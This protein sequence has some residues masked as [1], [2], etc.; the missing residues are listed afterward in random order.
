MTQ[1]IKEGKLFFM[2]RLAHEIN[3]RGDTSHPIPS[4]LRDLSLYKSIRF[5][6]L[7]SINNQNKQFKAMSILWREFFKSRGIRGRCG[8]IHTTFLFLL[9]FVMG[10]T[11]RSL[12][13][14]INEENVA[15]NF[16]LL[17]IGSPCI[18]GTGRVIRFQLSTTVDGASEQTNSYFTVDFGDGTPIVRYDVNSTVN[19]DPSGGKTFLYSYGDSFTGNHTYKT[20][21]KCF[22][23]VVTQWFDDVGNGYK[24]TKTKIV[25]WDTDDK[26]PDGLVIGDQEGDA[27]KVVNDAV[28]GAPV[29]NLCASTTGY[30]LTSN[31]FKD[32]SDWNCNLKDDFSEYELGDDGKYPLNN[33]RRLVIWSYGIKDDS[34]LDYLDGVVVYDASGPHT[35]TSTE[36]VEP[37]IEYPDAGNNIEVTP[38]KLPGVQ[39]IDIPSTTNKDVGKVF[40]ITLNDENACGL[41]TSPAIAYIKIVG[42][43]NPEVEDKKICMPESKSV[44]VTFTDDS[45]LTPTDIVWT[46]TKPDGSAE[47]AVSIA[48]GQ[49]T[50]TITIDLSKVDLSTTGKI[51]FK[52]NVRVVAGGDVC[53]GT[54][55][56]TI[57]ILKQPDPDFNLGGT[58]TTVTKKVCQSGT[59]QLSYDKTK[60]L[61]VGENFTL[62][63]DW[64]D[65]VS[66][67]IY[68]GTGGAGTITFNHTYANTTDAVQT[69]NAT[70]TVSNGTC[71]K[72]SDPH[73]V[74]VYPKPTISGAAGP[75]CAKPSITERY[76]CSADY[77]DLT[78]R[79]DVTLPDG[80]PHLGEGLKRTLD[81][82]F[83]QNG[84]YKLKV[85]ISDGG[86]SQE[87]DEYDVVVDKLEV[88]KSSFTKDKVCADKGTKEAT[89]ELDLSKPTK[90]R[91]GTT[92]TVDWGSGGTAEVY[93]VDAP[94]N[95]RIKYGASVPD[96][97]ITKTYTYTGDG[98][99]VDER[100]VTVTFSNSTGSCSS[101]IPLKAK[102][103]PPVDAGFNLPLS[104][105][106]DEEVTFDNTSKGVNLSYEW[107]VKKG[108]A[109]IGTADNTVKDLVHTFATS[110]DYLVGLEVTS[111]DGCPGETVPFK[112]YEVV[113]ITPGFRFVKNSGYHIIPKTQKRVDDIEVQ[114]TNTLNFKPGT[115]YKFDFG[116]TKGIVALHN[117]DFDPVTHIYTDVDYTGLTTNKFIYPVELTESRLGCVYSTTRNISIYSVGA[118]FIVTPVDAC[119]GDYQLQD[120]SDISDDFKDPG[121]P[122]EHLFVVR[123]WSVSTDGGL[124]YTSKGTGELF[125]LNY[126]NNSGTD[127]T[128]Y[129]KLDLIV[130]IDGT[131][132][133]G[134]DL[135]KTFTAIQHF[136]VP[137]A[138]QVS[139][140]GTDHKVC[141]GN[142]L[143][144]RPYNVSS[145]DAPDS[146]VDWTVS[147]SAYSVDLKSLVKRKSI[148][149]LNADYHVFVFNSEPVAG[150]VYT[151]NFTVS[152]NI[153]NHHSTSGCTAVKTYNIEV[154]D[155]SIVDETIYSCIGKS[156]TFTPT[157]GGGGDPVTRS[158]KWEVTTGSS[159]DLNVDASIT[160][161]T[162]DV[163]YDNFVFVPSV[164][165]NYVIKYTATDAGGCEKSHNFAL[166]VS[167]QPDP[168]TSAIQLGSNNLV[169]VT[170]E[171]HYRVCG[172]GVTLDGLHKGTVPT[173]DMQGE[174]TFLNKPSGAGDPTITTF[175]GLN[176]SKV[177]VTNLVAGEYDF[178]YTLRNH[179]SGVDASSLACV[180]SRI[181]KVN[182]YD[183]IS[184]TDA[185]LIH[186]VK[187]DHAL[188]SGVALSPEINVTGG[189]GTYNFAW[190]LV[191]STAGP[192]VWNSTDQNP[193][194]S[195][196]DVDT[197]TFTVTVTDQEDGVCVATKDITMSVLENVSAEAVAPDASTA[198]GSSVQPNTGHSPSTPIYI[199][200]GKKIVLNGSN[201]YPLGTQPD[202]SA[203]DNIT[204][205]WSVTNKDGVVKT[206]VFNWRKTDGS[207]SNNFAQEV[208]VEADAYGEYTFVYTI[209]NTSDPSVPIESRVEV[210]VTFVRPI[211]VTIGGPLTICPVGTEDVGGGVT[212]KYG[213]DG[214]SSSYVYT[215]TKDGDPSGDYSG[216]LIED[217]DP[218]AGVIGITTPKI[219]FDAENATAGI[220]NV[221]LTVKDPFNGLSSHS[222]VR[223]VTVTPALDPQ[224]A[225]TSFVPTS[226]GVAGTVQKANIFDVSSP[227]YYIVGRELTLEGTDGGIALTGSVS[228]RWEK[229][230]GASW[231]LITNNS[232][233]N[234]VSTGE[235][236]T[237]PK[238]PYGLMTIR[239]NLGNGICYNDM[240]MR[241]HFI[242]PIQI[243]SIDPKYFCH[244]AANYSLLNK[245]KVSGGSAEGVSYQWNVSDGAKDVTLLTLSNSTALSPEIL[246][247]TMAVGDYTFTLLVTD[248]H[249]NIQSKSM[250]FEVHIL[251]NPVADVAFPG[252]T[253]GTKNVIL[254]GSAYKVI[255]SDASIDLT[256]LNT[257]T[258]GKDP[259]ANPDLKGEWVMLAGPDADTGDSWYSNSKV[260]TYTPKTAGVYSFQWSLTNITPTGVEMCESSKLVEVEFL[261]GLS[262]TPQGEQ[263]LC[264]NGG[265]SIDLKDL[266]LPT[267][268]SGSYTNYR[269]TAEKRDLDDDAGSK[270]NATPSIIDSNSPDAVLPLTQEGIYYISLEVDDAK[271]VG[272]VTATQRMVI[273]PTEDANAG[274]DQ[275]T[276][277]ESVD[278][279]A[280]A[281][282]PIDGLTREGTWT[283]SPASTKVMFMPTSVGYTDGTHDPKAKFVSILGTR[284]RFTLTW[285][286]NSEKGESCPISDQM[287]VDFVPPITIGQFFD[288]R[289]SDAIV[290][291]GED[292]F[293]HPV[294]AGGSEDKAGG[295]IDNYT[296]SW[297]TTGSYDITSFLRDPATF[298]ASDP[299][300]DVAV[301]NKRNLILKTA[302][303]HPGDYTLTLEVSDPV[304]GYC[305][306]TRE[307]DIKI[308][309]T[310]VAEA[311]VKT[312]VSFE[313]VKDQ[314]R[315]RYYTCRKTVELLGSNVGMT[316]DEHGV[317]VAGTAVGHVG[318]KGEW[319]KVGGPGVITFAKADG[320]EGHEDPNAQ[321]IFS[322]AGEYTIQW[323]VYNETKGLCESTKVIVVDVKEPITVTFKD[324]PIYVC[325]DDAAFDITP[326]FSGGSGSGYT[327]FVWTIATVVD[328]AAT[329]GTYH[330]D[331]TGKS[332]GVYTLGVTANDKEG[333]VCQG[334]GDVDV[335]IVKKPTPNIKKGVVEFCGTS[336]SLSADALMKET[337][338]DKEQGRWR[339]KPD[340]TSDGTVTF[341]PASSNNTDFIVSNKGH[342]IFEWVVDHIYK[343]VA[344]VEVH[345]C[346][347]VDEIEI[348]VRITP[349]VTIEAP[350]H[351]EC[352]KDIDPILNI[353]GDY[354]SVFWELVSGPKITSTA[355]FSDNTV[356][357]PTVTVNDYGKY[358]FRATVSNGACSDQV[359]EMEYTFASQPVAGFDIT[360]DLEGC[361]PLSVTVNNSTTGDAL[362]DYAYQ[363]K[364][365]DP[366]DPTDAT[367]L[368][369]DKD[370]GSA[371]TIRNMSN[372]VKD[373]NIVLTV[374]NGFCSSTAGPKPV[375]VHPMP[376]VDFN[377]TSDSGCSPVVAEMENKTLFA[378][379]YE[380]D[381]DEDGTW[382]DTS[383]NPTHT[384][385]NSDFTKFNFKIKLRATKTTNDAFGTP[386][387]CP[388]TMEKIISVSPKP[389]FKLESDAAASGVCSPEEV[390]FT[391]TVGAIDYVWNYGDGS[392][393]TTTHYVAMQDHEFTYPASSDPVTDPFVTYKV[394]VDATFP[395]GCPS[396]GEVDVKVYPEMISNF[397]PSKTEV[398]SGEE[399]TFT[400]NAAPGAKKYIW[401]FNGDIVEQT[402]FEPTIDHTFNI[403]GY[404]MIPMNVSLT[405]ENDLCTETSSQVIMVKPKAKAD[406]DFLAGKDSFCSGE[407]V[408]FVN[409]SV[410]GKTFTWDYGEGTPDDKGYY[411]YTNTG[412]T[413]ITKTVTLIADNGFCPHDTSRVITI[414]HEVKPKWS[415][416]VKKG[417]TPLT[418]E[419]TNETVGGA[420]ATIS[421]GDGTPDEVVT[422]RGTVTHVFTNDKE[423]EALYNVSMT[424]AANAAGDCRKTLRDVIRVSP[425]IH[426]DF[427]FV[428]DGTTFCSGDMVMF[429]N[430]TIGV[431]DFDWDYGDGSTGKEAYHQYSN[432]T[433]TDVPRK[434]KLQV[435][436]YFGCT[437]E[438][439]KEITVM[440]EAQPRMDVVV[441]GEC[442]PVTVTV[443]NNTTGASLMTLDWG[444]GTTPVDVSTMAVG[445]TKTYEYNNDDVYIKT[446]DI[447]LSAAPAA[448]GSCLKTVSHRVTVKPEV[449]ASFE[450][451]KGGCSPL[452]ASVTNNSTG[453]IRYN[454]DFGVDSDPK[455]K[456]FM[457]A[458]KYIYRNTTL[459][460]QKY[461]VQLIAISSFGCRDTVNSIPI[462]IKPEPSVSFSLN[463]DIREGCAPLKSHFVV[464]SK[465]ANKH[466]WEI[467]KG[468]T[469]VKNIVNDEFGLYEEEFDHVY[470]NTDVF[471]RDFTLRLTGEN[472]FG[473]KVVQTTEMNIK[474]EVVSDFD[475]SIGEVCSPVTVVFSAASKSTG[476]SY[477][478]WDFGNDSTSVIPNPMQVF[479]NDTDKPKEF[480]VKL[481]TSSGECYG[482]SSK[483]LTIQ[484]HMEANFDLDKINGCSPVEVNIKN[485]SIRC[486][487]YIWSFDGGATAENI[488]DKI[489]SRTF[490][491]SRTSSSKFPD[492]RS[493]S[494]NATN[495]Y[496]RST[497]TK[498][499]KIFAPAKAGFELSGD[500]HCSPAKV[501]FI[502][503]SDHSYDVA[504]DFDDGSI[505]NLPNPEHLFLNESSTE[506]V[507]HIKQTVTTRDK[508]SAE[509]IKTY[510]MHPTPKVDFSI[511]PIFMIWPEATVSVENL[512][513][514][515]PWRFNWSFGEYEGVAV[516]DV[517][518]DPYTYGRVGS[519]DVKLEVIGE[520]CT[521][522]HKETVTIRPGVPVASFTPS[523]TE[524]CGPLKVKFT[525]TSKNGA[526]YYWD[527]GDGSH[528]TQ[529]NPEHTFHEENFYNV[530]LT[531]RNE[532][533]TKSEAEKTIH[534]FPVPVAFFTVQ[535]T[536]VEIPGQKAIFSN[537]SVNNFENYWEFGDGTTTTEVDP[538]HEY[539]VQG[540][541]DVKLRVVSEDGCQHTFTREA[542]VTAVSNGRVKVPNAFVPSTNGPT[543]GRYDK[544]DTYNRFFYSIVPEGEAKVSKYD[545]KIVNRWGNLVFHTSD[546]NI[547]WDGY[548]NGKLAPMDVYI[549]QIEVSFDDG[550]TIIQSGDVTLIR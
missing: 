474:P 279:N 353:E 498:P 416:N 118:D 327:D 224:V 345:R 342:Y 243:E 222:K 424:V 116:G 422:A 178:T 517:N 355:N 519:F 223:K 68:N 79:W 122:G 53:D 135:S 443:T 211:R 142:N 191:G 281:V 263:A 361:S 290:C 308:K 516:H 158:H 417:C 22:Y 31:P 88:S 277:G 536:R 8:F 546:I 95:L 481:V 525:N 83:D 165:G 543:D 365:V 228:G 409:K 291:A 529:E 130:T 457:P 275:Q 110:G 93:E 500:G 226:F 236:S 318:I 446:F 86:C 425:L 258:S 538:E 476:A 182:V 444:D 265:A 368:S 260:E 5:R 302:K 414:I 199:V 491:Y 524:G 292:I 48:S 4:E 24:V 450:L 218:V 159:S 43:P 179:A 10:F 61:P 71:D 314:G 145:L 326:T 163:G 298:D 283:V 264:K 30:S 252:L 295:N 453:A 483:T 217:D 146:N 7:K 41:S 196:N 115:E 306:T 272:T 254:N 28:L 205:E 514:P 12:G 97:K 504:W 463:P 80:T 47:T 488:P 324:S 523:V 23:E 246:V 253:D 545:L 112:D 329:T 395:G 170:A 447:I 70:L 399:M 273:I 271:G 45:G 315:D 501:N 436:N 161:G 261:A 138:P 400:N 448:D 249:G 21:D 286:I 456:N 550:N 238:P 534:V 262:V 257:A 333:D 415:F 192:I 241:L 215:I 429:E 210:K 177:N 169:E 404:G 186:N 207:P 134:A 301:K 19:L 466:T 347:A 150:T 121:T 522:T 108:A 50:N 39:R 221:R 484:P 214:T 137:P 373:R 213:T 449:I 51:V 530:K 157:V 174:W 462:E 304:S 341:T 475:M 527:F 206:S 193:T 164:A 231:D 309:E 91:V 136:V 375:K 81:Y 52:A 458:P 233:L 340:G 152:F 294:V 337:P 401:N 248:N 195:T 156:T 539:L 335:I 334:T 437:D 154:S 225:V 367:V 92:Y 542:A 3:C 176:T 166:E 284:G 36:Y 270:V 405:V 511:R 151:G 489:F 407:Q 419:I 300:T 6:K 357:K 351:P 113:E 259:D 540:V 518:P 515:G 479:Y 455:S 100:D 242:E 537:L 430:T 103:I 490:T 148:D 235:T 119:S 331:P 65:G 18:T 508:C 109:T 72:T 278:L 131:T 180:E 506:K 74:V 111:D 381:F 16:N 451:S 420:D 313:Y 155:I 391:A 149:S 42:S 244:G 77:A 84:T 364:E 289:T 339:L 426:A 535:P 185:T 363:W 359:V 104:H 349:V 153:E 32:I 473:C 393:P 532:E 344:G 528:S 219:E 216:L 27:Y 285:T 505:S 78:Y 439:E 312:G 362:T 320:K 101:T 487:D 232:T 40:K 465:G 102:I 352:D 495:K 398:C 29:L 459:D 343:N 445:E 63:A 440:H 120:D 132:T 507:Y 107:T 389:D 128:L 547:G 521:G 105:C 403:V 194:Y 513:N 469:I 274:V 13:Q 20:K 227:E 220:Y 493:I 147:N 305:V 59:L 49:G 354:Q 372:L 390:N 114:L 64:G 60:L 35:I 287:V 94:G 14:V 85:T 188:S 26:A 478:E 212:V 37:E 117:T 126:V 392:S 378:D 58:G 336:G 129:V 386:Y 464:K 46:L 250:T 477:Y 87:S 421:F 321:A 282:T 369:Y 106:K 394:K 411:T 38:D 423:S 503:T 189:S 239:W 406:F 209:K 526:T 139:A 533:G 9:L 67:V 11:N 387:A 485:T 167:E 379:S 322:E 325:Q 184:V 54:D 428:G 494:L 140:E 127:K 269:W 44:T 328:G 144:L 496:C 266:L 141:P 358:V 310:P 124:T 172:N 73:T 338:T 256:G 175:S 200:S 173:G 237:S 240:G 371:F 366:S 15:T 541:H 346:T 520:E 56:G 181:V 299:T 69:R 201:R 427:S 55:Y 187:Q 482:E 438:I 544:G 99:S 251:E 288:G 234:F 96:W 350:D 348:D 303:A 512:T 276:C 434:V 382:D 471:P 76:T 317:Q 133:G 75:L 460:I 332:P 468:E 293:V 168:S 383:E 499:F 549:W 433:L 356:L 203:S 374:T 198:E 323:L 229:Y 330:F 34:S 90:G 431:T 470:N 435:Q 442:S 396:T 370:P 432:T 208:E 376:Q 125:S 268:G 377:Y 17:K 380:W 319:S 66:E 497:L 245:V 510:T 204:G 531:V 25:I 190:T 454:W 388:S 408:V 297:T 162:S 57:T 410:G 384:F 267:G 397:T 307:F 1:Y 467:D 311:V 412:L 461:K 230:N 171:T 160:L 548:Y 183:P 98:R 2:R 472:N 316:Y 82:T 89:F 418:V 502:S 62:T 509:M 360:S 441:S 123:N 33:N 402:T 280:N 143:E 385:T 296:Y 480:T 452:I 197:Y 492:I 202:D 255:T 486:D 247:K 413:D